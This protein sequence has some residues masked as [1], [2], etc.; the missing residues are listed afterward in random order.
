MAQSQVNLAT[1]QRRELVL[2]VNQRTR[3]QGA[4]LQRDE[5]K[6]LSGRKWSRST[7]PNRPKGAE[8]VSAVELGQGRARQGYA[9]LGE[10]GAILIHV[11][12]P[13]K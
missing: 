8:A 10:H 3:P 2:N 5:H 9:W 11:E 4:R 13:P 6:S 1:Q 7:E 12:Q